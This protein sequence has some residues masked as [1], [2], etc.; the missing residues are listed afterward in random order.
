MK[1]SFLRELQK[2]ILK[3]RGIYIIY[4]FIFIVTFI[5]PLVTMR[6][7]LDIIRMVLSLMGLTAII[8]IYFKFKS[9]RSKKEDKIIIKNI[10]TLVLL[11][12]LTIINFIQGLW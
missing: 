9:S 7:Y 11:S 6:F 2:D 4:L 10:V 1:G 8:S 3:G 5:I 12:F